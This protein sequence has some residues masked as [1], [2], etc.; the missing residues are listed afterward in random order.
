MANA[1]LDAE[2]NDL[3]EL[4]FVD[5]GDTL[6]LTGGEAYGALTI[7]DTA[8]VEVDERIDE[9]TAA[10]I[11]ELNSIH[12]QSN[13]LSNMSGTIASTNEVSASTDALVSAGLPWTITPGTF[14]VVVYDA[15]DTATT[16]TITI[17]ATTTLDDLATVLNGIAN[18][19]ASVSGNTLSLGTSSPYSFTFSNDTTGALPALGI[20]GLFVGTD[21]SSITVNQDLLDNPEWLGSGYSTDALDS[22]DNEAALAMAAVQDAQILDS[23]LS[24]INEHYQST[25][26]AI[27][28]DA[29]A[30]EQTLEVQQSF[31][32]DFE[33]RRQEVSGVS[34]DEEVTSLILYQRAFEAS[35]RVITVT[36]RMLEVLL[37]VG[38]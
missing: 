13:G 25:I 4:R 31:V 33:Q 37:S 23:G 28:V 2:R 21:A 5:N 14:D 35:A 7:R 34:L 30:N 29:R 3:V 18:F 38:A 26:A 15:S 27:G 22:G 12:S 19:S 16:T 8:L 1:A 32:D 24:T 11:Y 6:D 9:L 36:D 17:A 20:N 10:L